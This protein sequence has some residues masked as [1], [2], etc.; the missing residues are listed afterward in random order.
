MIGTVLFIGCDTDDVSD[1]MNKKD[2][3][4]NVASINYEIGSIESILRLPD[5][6]SQGSRQGCAY[7]G[8]TLLV[9]HNTNDIV[10]VYDAENLIMKST[11]NMR[12]RGFCNS[13]YHCNNANFSNTRY[14]P[15]DFYPLLY[16]SMENINQHCILV[17]RITGNLDCLDFDLIQTILLPA[18]SEIELFYPNC[19]VDTEKQSLWI[20]GYSTN[21]FYISDDNNLK[22]I[23]FNLPDICVGSIVEFSAKDIQQV[24]IFDSVSATQGGCF[25]EGNLFQVFGITVPRHFMIFNL[26]E[27]TIIHDNLLTLFDAEPEGLY[28]KEGLVYYITEY[29]LLKINFKK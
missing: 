27:S 9:F 14:A 13:E 17:F 7:Y 12:E 6:S 10:E 4:V 21:N 16:V 29:Y 18:P 3:E 19:Y 15:T 1:S 25:F 26:Y 8:G 5:V 22:Y 2:V 28:I 11:F 20:S 24:D 23:R